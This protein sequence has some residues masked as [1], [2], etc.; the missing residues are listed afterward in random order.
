MNN[1]DMMNAFLYG[2]YR[3]RSL[4]EIFPDYGSFNEEFN[5]TP[6]SN[7]VDDKHLKLTLK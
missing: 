7:S 4:S 3:T 1:C 2:S 5:D 6:F